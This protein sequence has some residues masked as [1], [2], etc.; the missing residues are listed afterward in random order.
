MTL[1]HL[2]LLLIVSL[3][4]DFVKLTCHNAT[5]IDEHEY[6]V[7]LVL[8]TIRQHQAHYSAIAF[9]LSVIIL[10]ARLPPFL[11]YIRIETLLVNS[12]CNG[13]NLYLVLMMPDMHEL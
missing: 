4:A 8:C 5:P 12:L 13:P 10:D 3:L 6:N 2:K 7:S 9:Y 1:V 11:L